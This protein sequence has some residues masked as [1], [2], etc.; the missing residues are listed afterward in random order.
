MKKYFSLS[1]HWERTYCH[2]IVAYQYQLYVASKD[3]CYSR[4]QG[5]KLRAQSFPVEKTENT[6]VIRVSDKKG[7]L[8]RKVRKQNCNEKER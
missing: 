6:E 8:N 3:Q 1:Q 7:K 2:C 5:Y 4:N